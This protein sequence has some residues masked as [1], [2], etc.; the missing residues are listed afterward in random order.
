M[1]GIEKRENR[2][3]FKFI[4]KANPATGSTEFVNVAVA[5]GTVSLAA[6]AAVALKK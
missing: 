1:Q 3:T 2:W 6:A 4:G 5:L